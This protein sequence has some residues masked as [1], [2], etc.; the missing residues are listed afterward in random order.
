MA[1]QAVIDGVS[2]A[3]TALAFIMFSSQLPA[4][5]VVA[6]KTRS[7]DKL[8]ALPTAGMAANCGAWVIY[9][10]QN[11]DAALFRVNAIGCGFAV[12]YLALF[13]VY[14]A[15]GTPRVR[16]LTLLGALLGA[17]APIW[18]GLIAGVADK[19]TRIT[20]LGVVA[21]AC[22]VAMYAAPL[23]IIAKA[24][25]DLDPTVIPFLLTAANTLLSATWMAYGFLVNNWFVAGPNIAGTTLS[26]AQLLAATYVSYKVATDPDAAAAAAAR[27]P[28]PSNGFDGD[29]GEAGLLVNAGGDGG[30]DDSGLT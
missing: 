7:V 27:K 10:T 25:K 29:D 12:L 14:T 18:A 15:P 21:V 3:G 1:P 5:W 4:F 9:A 23:Q 13:L 11:G 6:T 2:T 22:N 30:V 20:A 24:V 26:V 16:L 17:G 28:R 19:D 8:S